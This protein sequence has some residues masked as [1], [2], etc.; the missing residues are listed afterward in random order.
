MDKT[1]ILYCIVT[2][3]GVFIFCYQQY[4][5]HQR[6]LLDKFTAICNDKA[7]I[8]SLLYQKIGQFITKVIKN[9]VLIAYLLHCI[10][11]VLD[12]FNIM[13]LDIWIGFSLLSA[14]MLWQQFIYVAAHFLVRRYSE[15]QS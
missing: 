7:L 3:V 9:L 6:G 2:M 13:S 10:S 15:L 11:K 8:E 12:S 1:F 4:L 14:Y 5:L